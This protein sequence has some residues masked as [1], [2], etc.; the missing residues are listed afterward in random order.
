MKIVGITKTT[1]ELNNYNWYSDFYCSE[2]ILEALRFDLN[3]TY[4]NLEVLFN[5]KIYT[6]SPNIS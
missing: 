4:S 1:N 2:K 5:D 3:E 6:Y